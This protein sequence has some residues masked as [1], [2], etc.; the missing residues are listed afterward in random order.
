MADKEAWREAKARGDA[1]L[2]QV[3]QL[4]RPTRFEPCGRPQPIVARARQPLRLSVTE[5]ETLYRDPYAIYARHILG[6]QPLEPLAVALGVSD[7][8]SLLHDIVS[9]FAE[10]YASTPPLI[11]SR[12]HW[13]ALQPRPSRRSSHDLEVQQFWWPSWQRLAGE[14]L[15]WEEARRRDI[16][17][18]ATEAPARWT[19]PLADGA[20]FTLTARAD[21]VERSLTAPCG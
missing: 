5:I 14:V 17:A 13:S 2:A 21:R 18:L 12:R 9:R 1:L 10:V 19:F 20:Q 4:D 3:A 8:G 6:L 7:R 16:V 15:G 11:A